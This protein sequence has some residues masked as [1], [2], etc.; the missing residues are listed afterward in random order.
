MTMQLDISGASGQGAQMRPEP[1]PSQGRQER[2]LF[3]L[4]QALLSQ[5]GQKPAPQDTPAQRGQPESPPAAGAPTIGGLSAGRAG[6]PASGG[7]VDQLTPSLAPSLAV[8]GAYA[9]YAVSDAADSAVLASTGSTA[10]GA[11]GM[12]APAAAG[13][14]DRS[15]NNALQAPPR[16]AASAPGLALAPG[17]RA[18][19]AMPGTPQPGMHADTDTDALPQP[20]AARNEAE[21]IAAR[22]MHLYRAGDGVHAWI[23]D[24]ALSEGQARLVAQAMALELRASG[25]RLQAMT[26]NG[27]V[28]Q[29]AHPAREAGDVYV[30]GQVDEDRNGAAGRSHMT[31][32]AI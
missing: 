6:Q 27:K 9:Q 8:P 32:D 19:P 3:E 7:V 13:V 31:K 25:G 22:Q 23:R 17:N 12:A 4:E 15:A 1:P 21:E 5:Q 16:L 11:A 20:R 26:V 24:A 29:L 10:T 2:W 18:L 30:G 14:R 28:L